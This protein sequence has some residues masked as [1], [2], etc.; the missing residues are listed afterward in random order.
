MKENGV[1][2][3]HD[4]FS[5]L[6]EAAE[7]ENKTYSNGDGQRILG[8][9][10]WHSDYDKVLSMLKEGYCEL[11]LTHYLSY[12]L[13]QIRSVNILPKTVGSRVHETSTA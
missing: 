11:F 4:E 7:C 8:V 9:I 6:E 5:L 2:T 3:A 12:T 1:I 13:P 10:R